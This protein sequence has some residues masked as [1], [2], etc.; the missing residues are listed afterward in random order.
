[1]SANPSRN[2][3]TAIEQ[4]AFITTIK[5]ISKVGPYKHA[6]LAASFYRKILSPPPPPLIVVSTPL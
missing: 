6:L 5:D 4:C 1:M 2:S 3:Q